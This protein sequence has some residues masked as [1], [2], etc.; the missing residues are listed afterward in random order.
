[1]IVY[2]TLPIG[3]RAAQYVTSADG[4]AAAPA[5]G[6]TALT[7][8]CRGQRR[9]LAAGAAGYRYWE[10]SSLVCFGKKDESAAGFKKKIAH[11]SFN[12]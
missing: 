1:M 11:Y 8:Q 9:L 7:N 4:S 3:R 2:V 5:S 12:I 10:K 6:G